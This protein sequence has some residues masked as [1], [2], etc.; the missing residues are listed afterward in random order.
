[1]SLSVRRYAIV[2]VAGLTLTTAACGSS[3]SASTSTTGSKPGT[4][5]TSSVG[6]SATSPSGAG[7]TIGFV[8]EQLQVAS[9]QMVLHAMKQEGDAKGYKVVGGD[10]KNTASGQQTAIENLVAAGAKCV[11][12]RAKDKAAMEAVAEQAHGQHS[13]V[14]AIYDSFP[15][16]DVTIGQDQLAI[17]KATGELG[18]KYL[19]EHFGG[20]GDVMVLTAD[21]LGGATVD[22]S[23]GIIE[24]LKEGAPEAKVVANVDAYATAKAEAAVSS[25]LQAHP[26]IRLVVTVNT[27]GAEGALSALQNAGKKTPQ[28]ASVVP[29]FGAATLS[30]L[31]EIKKGSVYGTV[32]AKTLQIGITAVDTCDKLIRGDSVEQQITLQGYPTIVQDNVDKQISYLGTLQGSNEGS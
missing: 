20:K 2:A 10:A 19:V 11:V 15:G 26:D 22:R 18:A 3:G 24:G 32:D 1:M 13:Y 31:Q 23:K 6:P 8:P 21:S 14:V 25:A 29:A 4:T 9:F 30:T 17:G 28:D 16:A 27:A 7:G 5:T 12:V